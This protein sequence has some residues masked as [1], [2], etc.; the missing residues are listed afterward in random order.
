VEVRHFVHSAVI[1]NH[2]KRSIRSIACRRGFAPA[3]RLARIALFSLVADQGR[4]T[5]LAKIGMAAAA[6][7][8]CATACAETASA[9]LIQLAQAKPAD[10]QVC[11]LIYLPVCG[12][13]NGKP[14]NFGNDCEA[15]R[16][17][18]RNIR[19]GVCAPKG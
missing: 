15:K 17:K 14:T 13:V 19:P 10:G 8:I 3:L 4:A 11:T 5:M 6:T 16:A 2:V 18:A 7:L 9:K 12:E 1:S